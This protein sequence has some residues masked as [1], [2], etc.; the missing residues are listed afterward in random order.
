MREKF[1]AWDEGISVK[2]PTFERQSRKKQK[3]NIII[4]GEIL[5]KF[6]DKCYKEPTYNSRTFFKRLEEFQRNLKKVLKGSLI[7]K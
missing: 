2:I 1:D 7:I 6:Q 4:R 3:K 5:R